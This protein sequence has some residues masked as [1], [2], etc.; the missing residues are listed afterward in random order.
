[1]Y[2]AAWGGG[3]GKEGERHKHGE[4][5]RHKHGEGE[6]DT[7]RERGKKG[8]RDTLSLQFSI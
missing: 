7:E 1:M 4:G 5:E 2:L 6:R 8:E 3:G